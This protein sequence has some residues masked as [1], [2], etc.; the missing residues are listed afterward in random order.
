MNHYL[1]PDVL[2]LADVFENFR[3]LSLENYRL[4]PA[5]YVNS[6]QL[7]WDAMV[8]NTGCALELISDPEM[9]HMMDN[10]LRG[11]VSMIIHRYARANNPEMEAQYDPAQPLAY[12]MYLEAN[13]LYGHAMSQSLPFH[14][15]RWLD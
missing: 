14:Y 11:G 6:P 9:F 2:I 10:G 13:N 1:K 15:F 12:I 5:H 4:D 3:K 8:L 7:S